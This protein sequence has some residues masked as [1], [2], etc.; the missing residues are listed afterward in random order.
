MEKNWP[1]IPRYPQQAG[2]LAI[3]SKMLNW[4]GI[5]YEILVVLKEYGACTT[6]SM[7]RLAEQYLEG[8]NHDYTALTSS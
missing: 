3:L 8:A 5:W 6:C 4:D 1:R 2:D 7:K